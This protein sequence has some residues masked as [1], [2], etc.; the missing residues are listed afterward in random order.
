MLVVFTGPINCQAHFAASRDLI[1]QDLQAKPFSEIFG[2]EPRV[3]NEPRE[4]FGGSLL[5]DLYTRQFG[6]ATGLFTMIA[7][8]NLV[9]ALI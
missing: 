9:I 6:L 2:L 8:T 4:L 7:R 3:V 1:G 5:I